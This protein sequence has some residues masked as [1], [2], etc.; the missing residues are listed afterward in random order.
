MFV[1]LMIVCLILRYLIIELNMKLILILKILILTIMIVLLNPL[2]MKLVP[3][4]ESPE[5][6]MPEADP[7]NDESKIDVEIDDSS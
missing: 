4:V 3:Y 6:V 5:I 7:L 2:N 1:V